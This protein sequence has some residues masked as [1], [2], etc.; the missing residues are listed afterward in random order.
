[1]LLSWSGSM[2]E[3]LMPSRDVHAEQQSARRHVPRPPVKLQ[4]EYGTERGVRGA[5]RNPHFR[6]ATRPGLPILRVLRTGPGLQARLS[7][8][9]VVAPYATALAAMYEKA[10][11]RGGFRPV[12]S[13]RRP[14]HLRFLR[15][16]STSR[17][18]DCPRTRKSGGTRVLRSSSGQWRLSHSPMRWSTTSC[19]SAFIA[20]PMIEAA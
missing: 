3:Y 10:R 4:I 19:A 9:L 8:E 17:R 16:A 7:Q 11:C 12:A 18:R 14:R 5:F 6:L 2:F 1:M 15:S 13:C 20:I